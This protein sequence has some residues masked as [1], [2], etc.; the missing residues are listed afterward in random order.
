MRP[1]SKR[2]QRVYRKRRE[3]VE[4]QLHL[5]PLCER[6]GTQPSVDVHEVVGRGRGG[7]ILDE[8]NVRCLCRRCHD[9]ITTRP[10][11]AER[12]GFVASAATLR[13]PFLSDDT[14]YCVSCGLPRMNWRHNGF[15]AVA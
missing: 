5:Y 2:T 3:F 6:C 13:H 10:S 12:E 14:F 1:R 4:Q 7:S 11:Q 15:E 9:F 8:N